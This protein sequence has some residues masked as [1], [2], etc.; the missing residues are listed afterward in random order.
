MLCCL[1][2]FIVLFSLTHT[3]ILEW[4]LPIAMIGLM[5]WLKN[6]VQGTSGL[7]PKTVKASFPD[8]SD[9]FRPLTFT[10]YVTALQIP[11]VCKESS[12]FVE[13]SDMGYG[14]GREWQVPMLKCNHNLCKSDGQDATPFCQFNILAIAGEDESGKARAKDMYDYIMGRWPVLDRSKNASGTIP[15]DY[16]MVWLADSV[17]EIDDYVKHS[18]YGKEG[19][20]KVAFGI[21]WPEGNTDANYVY[22]LRQN[23]TNYNNVAIANKV[24]PAAITSPDTQRKFDTYARDDSSCAEGSSYE[25]GE[26]SDSCTARYIYNG[27]LPFQRLVNDFV[28]H[29]SKAEA[30]GYTVSEAGVSYVRFPSPEYEEDGFYSIAGGKYQIC[31]VSCLYLCF[32]RSIMFDFLIRS[33][34]CL[35]V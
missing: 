25:Y 12:G 14:G 17:Q 19:R 34:Y 31:S 5:V 26:R 21:V 9:V 35:L 3:Q 22:K 8:K 16:D 13:I 6:L 15:V 7:K 23:S 24:Q 28:L 1:V 33:L 2:S 20:P 10:D 27:V 29:D 11:R 32:G 30:A 18:E 4:L